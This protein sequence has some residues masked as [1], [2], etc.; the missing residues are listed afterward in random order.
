MERDD[1]SPTARGE[2]LRQ[3][4][5]THEGDHQKASR[6]VYFPVVP[7]EQQLRP[8]QPLLPSGLKRVIGRS[9]LICCCVLSRDGANSLCLVVIMLVAVLVFMLGVVPRGEFYSYAVVSLLTAA[10]I[11]CL[12]LSVTV[13]PGILLPLPHDPA[14]QPETVIVN[15]KEV[16]CKVCPT[17]HIVRPPRSTHCQFCDYCVEEFDH[18]CGV[19]GSCVAK[20]T[21]RFFG[22]YFV[23]TAFLT[24]YV[25]IRAIAALGTRRHDLATGQGRWEMGA[26]VLSIVAAGVGGCTAIPFALYYVYLA[27]MNSTQKEAARIPLGFC[28]VNH[29]YHQGCWR[30]FFRRYFGSL[31][32]SRITAENARLYV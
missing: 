10:A 25:G 29:D 16:L 18:H 15:G 28:E 8:F 17:C 9:H 24:L 4:P 27:C 20:R 31:G 13:D 21:F 19:V 30:N 2:Q 7:G 6:E 11:A 23:F 12:V 32:E 26:A 3:E 1:G 22:G 14:R 5:R